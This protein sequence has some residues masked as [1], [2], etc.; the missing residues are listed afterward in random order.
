MNKL[1]VAP[2]SA[3]ERKAY[4]RIRFSRMR[5]NFLDNSSLTK[6]GVYS[7]GTLEKS[8]GRQCKLILEAPQSG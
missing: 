6:R 3:T 2:L 7:P 4:V 8:G 1:T 5:Q